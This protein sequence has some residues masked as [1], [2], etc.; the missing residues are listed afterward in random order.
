MNV[1]I[2]TFSYSANSET[3]EFEFFEDD[4]TLNQHGILYGLS[5]STLLGQSPWYVFGSSGLIHA[6]DD[7]FEDWEINVLIEAGLGFSWRKPDL[8]FAL[9]YRGEFATDKDTSDFGHFQ[10]ITFTLAKRWLFQ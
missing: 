10:G 4:F 2:E 6:R 8:S 7:Q 3:Q 1:D 5:T 9:A